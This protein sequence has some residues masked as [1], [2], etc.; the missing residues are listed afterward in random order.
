MR[1][2][3]GSTGLWMQPR[4]LR[5]SCACLLRLTWKRTRYRR[6]YRSLQE[7]LAWTSSY[8]T[9]W[10]SADSSPRMGPNRNGPDMGCRYPELRDPVGRRRDPDVSGN[11]QAT[12]RYWDTAG[13]DGKRPDHV[14]DRRIRDRIDSYQVPGH[15]LGSIG[16][17]MACLT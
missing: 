16:S 7:L 14:W 8:L 6:I 1:W 15:N 2:E 3:P 10:S 11:G 4:R 12:T 9:W 5:W 17:G 13:E